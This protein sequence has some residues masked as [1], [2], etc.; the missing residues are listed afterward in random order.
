MISRQFTLL[1][2]SDEDIRKQY[3]DWR[4]LVVRFLI[5]EAQRLGMTLLAV[6]EHTDEHFMHVHGLYMADNSRLDMKLAHPGFLAKHQVELMI[7]ANINPKI[8]K[9]SAFKAAMRAW[10]DHVYDQVSA[11]SGLLRFG[12]RRTRYPADVLK[13]QVAEAKAMADKNGQLKNAAEQTRLERS[14]ISKA[15]LEIE[16]ER[17]K[18]LKIRDDV[19]D[20][21]RTQRARTAAINAVCDREIVGAHMGKLPNSNFV[22]FGSGVSRDRQDVLLKELSPAL[23][24]ALQII[25]RMTE[26]MHSGGDEMLVKGGNEVSMRP[27]P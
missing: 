16:A 26:A 18:L 8:S 25:I 24:A 4:E 3:F 12:P 5:A 13:A 21:Q 15:R 11:P 2:L 9:N 22:V 17:T 27:N 19:L 20:F 10:Q 23:V 1:D 7:K 6:V 14:S